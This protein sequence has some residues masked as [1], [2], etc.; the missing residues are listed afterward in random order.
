MAKRKPRKQAGGVDMATFL[1][2]AEDCDSQLNELWEKYA[3]LRTRKRG[4]PMTSAHEDA[5]VE[6]IRTLHVNQGAACALVGL[7]VKSVTRHTSGEQPERPEWAQSLAA[8]KDLAVIYWT[9]MMLLY[10]GDKNSPGQRTAEFMMKAL[11]PDV[12]REDRG[13]AA[14]AGTKVEIYIGDGPEGT[15]KVEIITVADGDSPGLL[16]APGEGIP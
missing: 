13:K 5:L 14:I 3:P 15:A 2:A 9:K 4:E 6:V 1:Q 8:A 7:D 10:A 12:Y 16:A 11:L